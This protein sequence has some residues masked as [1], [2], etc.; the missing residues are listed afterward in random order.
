VLVVRCLFIKAATMKPHKYVEPEGTF[1]RGL[2]PVCGKERDHST[3]R[4]E[5]TVEL[6]GNARAQSKVSAGKGR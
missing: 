6:A 3:H 5:A 1:W 4:A 2:C